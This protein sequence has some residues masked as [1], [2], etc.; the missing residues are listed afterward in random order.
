[1]SQAKSI[2]RA[3]L[4]FAPSLLIALPA[5][6]QLT[7]IYNEPLAQPASSIKPNIMLILDDSGS[8]QQQYTPDYLGRNGGGRNRLCFDSNDDG[9]GITTLLDNCEPGDP[10]LMTPQINTQYYNPEIR[11][12]PAVNFDGTSRPPMN[13]STSVT[14]IARSPSSRHK[15]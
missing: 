1:M 6:A 10:P 2:A 4:A 15:R 11:Y 12:D 5:H 13:A 9:D 14:G 3:I 7:E 8:M